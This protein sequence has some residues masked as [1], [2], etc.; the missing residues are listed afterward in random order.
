MQIQKKV[1]ICGILGVSIFLSTVNIPA[2]GFFEVSEYQDK[3]FE[4]LNKQGIID[5]SYNIL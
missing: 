2:L 1:K 3:V 4:I 5:K